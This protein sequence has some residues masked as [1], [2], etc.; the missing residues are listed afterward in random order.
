[1]TA[2]VKC[3]HDPAATVVYSW[4]FHV[5]RDPPSLNSRLFN[6]GARRWAYKRER[7]VWCLEFRAARLL[8][9]IGKAKGKRRVTLTRNY[10]GRQQH[11]DADNLAGG[12]KAVVD[13]L[14]LEQLLVNDDASHAEIHYAQA[15]TTPAGL[16][17]LIEELA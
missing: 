11:R 3:G 5:D 4:A 14:V 13:A 7:D 15:R 6:S 8:K 10:S 9:R 12:M 2:C 1:M 17:V 16:V